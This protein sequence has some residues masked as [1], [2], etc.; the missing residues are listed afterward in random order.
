MYDIAII[1]AGVAGTFIARELSRYKL[2]VILI[3]KNSDVAN[4]ATA[5]NG[6]TIYDGYDAKPD[7]FRGKLTIR[8]NELYDS[9]CNDLGVRFERVGLLVVA[10]RQE[11]RKTL[12]NLYHK[13]VV[14]VPGLRILE[15]DE[16]LTMEPCLSDK[17]VAA[18]YSP[19][20]GIVY[21]WELAIALVENAMD[22]GV[23]LLLNSEVTSIK[24]EN[25]FFQLMLNDGIVNAR[26]VIN[27][28]GIN[29]D[30]INE[31]VASP[32]F[33][34]G[35]KRGQFIVLDKSPGLIKRI[36]SQ[37]KTDGEKEVSV[38][39]TING[40]L[41]IGP[42]MESIEDGGANQ[43]TEERLAFIKRSVS[44]L[45]N[46]IPLDQIIQAFAGI[47]AKAYIGKDNSDFIIEESPEV[48]GFIN[49]AGINS[50]GLTC[51]PAIA[52]YVTK[53][54]WDIYQTAEEVLVE[55]VL[56]I[57]LRSKR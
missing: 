50:P 32:S 45:S 53:I 7:D 34:I 54:V 29:A 33:K 17:V 3:E 35:P 6:G 15:K 18:L 49:V 22:N 24:K 27:C 28:A 14:N 20:C 10:V 31:L 43:V 11:D 36:I 47:K 30:K 44:K 21:P 39:P 37:C 16:V 41:L 38:I 2:K 13:G 51:A 12:E 23:K 25:G 9:V 57:V 55:K 48:R 40:N 42:A 56:K 26:Y 4:E 8:G 52:E 46:K 5:A 19:T 1:G